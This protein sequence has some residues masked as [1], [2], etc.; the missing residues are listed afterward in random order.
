[1]VKPPSSFDGEGNV[2][3]TADGFYR[4]T[5]KEFVQENPFEPRRAD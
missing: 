1:M 4:K 5:G 3:Q 2:L